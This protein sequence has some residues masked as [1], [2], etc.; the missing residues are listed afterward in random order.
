M[1]DQRASFSAGKAEAK[2]AAA[3]EAGEGEASGWQE[4]GKAVGV[5]AG[6]PA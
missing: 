4:V 3:L 2:I 6:G 1:S 5:G